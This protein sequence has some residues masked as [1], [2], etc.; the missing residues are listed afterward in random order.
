MY[1]WPGVKPRLNGRPPSII[2]GTPCRMISMSVAHTAIAST[3]TSTSAG[4]GS[5]TG[6]STSDNS[7]GPPSTQ[8]FIL[9]GIGCS[10]LRG[11]VSARGVAMSLYP[12]PSVFADYPEAAWPGEC[13][14]EKNSGDYQELRGLLFDPDLGEVLTDEMARRDAPA[15]DLRGVRDD[16]VP[17]QERHRIRLGQP[18]A[19]E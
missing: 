3:R 13:G 4:P 18:V 19:L 15:L 7:S 17:P 10:L 2:A 16:A 1:S 8:A 11:A 14:S 5:G 9:S 6:F 12:M